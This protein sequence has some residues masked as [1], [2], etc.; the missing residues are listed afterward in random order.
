MKKKTRQKKSNVVQCTLFMLIGLMGLIRQIP[1][2]NLIGDDGNA[3][4]AVAY[5][6]G[7]M[8]LV[9]T[10]VGLSEAVSVMVEARMKR[11]QCRS[12]GRVL[13]S[14]LLLAALFSILAGTLVFLAAKELTGDLLKESLS[15]Y[16]LRACAPV[17]LILSVSGVLRGY[18]QG[19]GTRMPEIFCGVLVQSLL[20]L[21]MLIPAK[22]FTVYGEKV[23]RLL[24][25]AHF[26]AAYGAMGAV[27]GLL[28]GA[29]IGLLFLMFVYKLYRRILKKQ[30][31]RDTTRNVE[32]FGQMVKLLLWTAVPL[33]LPLFLYYCGHILEQALFNH[34]MIDNAMETQKAVQWGVYFGKYRVI[35]RIP[36]AVILPVCLAIVPAIARSVGK[37]DLKQAKDR[38]STC[39]HM[40]FFLA[41]PWAVSLGVLA[42]PLM[43]L[44]YDG[45]TALAISLLQTG[46]FLVVGLALAVLTSRILQAIGREKRV[47]FNAFV[48]FLVQMGLFVVFLQ[49][50]GLNVY[51]AVY[52]ELAA[53]FLL[54]FLNL[55][56][57]CRILHYRQEW[58]R[59]LLLPAGAAIA[60][61]IAEYLLFIG[62]CRLMGNLGVLPVALLGTV[63]YL[64]IILAFHG[65]SE[66]EL[67]RLPGGQIMIQAARVLR[68]L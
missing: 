17:L 63:L 11:G 21:F 60:A 49:Y 2:T 51:A 47:L 50:L 58:I 35:T 28:A 30:E 1:L 53:V 65:I 57:I 26:R 36:L 56:A 34:Y 13:S 43:E 41:M 7:M 39:M 5:E 45:E 22:K 37:T 8:V 66:L 52:A 64:L 20:F 19:I 18:F 55:T 14:S 46:S 44:F 33:F 38:I 62:F 6:L 3:Y 54:A 4:F 59:S 27:F 12:A 15:M 48:S 24:Q 29:I 9:I 23:G 25:N 16:A 42:K 32:S 61:G 31:Q 68:L 10:A 67:S 40:T